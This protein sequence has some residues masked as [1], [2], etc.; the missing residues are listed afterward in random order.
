MSL[1]TC[2]SVLLVLKTGKGFVIISETKV[3]EFGVQ[4]LLQYLIFTLGTRT[5]QGYGEVVSVCL[6]FCLCLLF[7]DFIVLS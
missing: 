3:Q 7:N 1:H 6:S 4:F 2:S 5:P